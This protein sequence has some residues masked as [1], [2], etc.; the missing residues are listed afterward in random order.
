MPRKPK[1]NQAEVP[2]EAQGRDLFETPN[3]A[4]DL[5]IS[6]IPKSILRIWECAAGDGKIANVLLKNH[7]YVSQSDIRLVGAISKEHNF[8]SDGL[9]E[10]QKSWTEQKVSFAIITNPPFSLKRKFYEKCLEYNV[11]FAL[12][13]PFDVNQ[14][15]CG[16]FDKY[17][18]QAL[19][20]NR[21]INYI[22][23]NGKSGK[24]SSAQF[25][26]FWLTRGFNLPKQLTVVDLP[27]SEMENI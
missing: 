8:L 10:H 22:T 9:T 16:A 20:P 18:C 2:N 15:L 24:D 3:Y 11:P 1:N 27:R 19:V 5:L 4:V 12:L 13:I 23:P 21:R 25:H 26:S 7:F 17:N 6:F 14:W